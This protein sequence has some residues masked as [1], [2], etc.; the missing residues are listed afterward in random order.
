[1]TA[2]NNIQ[3]PLGLRLAGLLSFLLFISAVVLGWMAYS[4]GY[5]MGEVIV[6]LIILVVL[7]GY[8]TWWCFH[9]AN[10]RAQWLRKKKERA[11]QLSAEGQSPAF[12]Q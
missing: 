1:M 11:Q 6:P 3:S 5:P 12:P 7:G 10:R 8:M 9:L 2:T 4:T